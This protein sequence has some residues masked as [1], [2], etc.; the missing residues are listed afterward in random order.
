MRDTFAV[1]AILYEALTGDL[2]MNRDDINKN[3]A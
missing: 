2:L 3:D 1:A